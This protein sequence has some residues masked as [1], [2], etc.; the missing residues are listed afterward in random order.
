MK[1]NIFRQRKILEI[2]SKETIQPFRVIF[3]VCIRIDEHLFC[4]YFQLTPYVC[5]INFSEFFILIIC[6]RIRKNPKALYNI[7]RLF[8]ILLLNLAFSICFVQQ[9][10]WQI[11]GKFCCLSIIQRA[12]LYDIRRQF[13]HP[14]KRKRKR[15]TSI[16]QSAFIPFRFL[17]VKI[18]ITIFSNGKYSSFIQNQMFYQHILYSLQKVLSRFAYYKSFIHII[19]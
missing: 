16:E 18:F 14:A 5:F 10:L 17:I 6:C 13:S 4:G 15:Y 3:E 9:I 12:F 19:C 11:S 1:E 8:P 2:L 7:Q